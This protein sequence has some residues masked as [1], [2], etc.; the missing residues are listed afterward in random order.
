MHWQCSILAAAFVV[1]ACDDAPEPAIPGLLTDAC[2]LL[3]RS[4]AETITVTWPRV[5]EAFAAAF[6]RSEAFRTRA[7]W[8]GWHPIE[9]TIAACNLGTKYRAVTMAIG[10]AASRGDRTMQGLL[11]RERAAECGFG[12]A[13]AEASDGMGVAWP[14]SQQRAWASACLEFFAGAPG[15]PMGG[16]SSRSRT[17]GAD[18]LQG[19]SVTGSDGTAPADDGCGVQHK[20]FLIQRNDAMTKRSLSA[21]DWLAY[22]NAL[23]ACGPEAEPWFA[24]QVSDRDA[25][26]DAYVIPFLNGDYARASAFRTGA[27]N[28]HATIMTAWGLNEE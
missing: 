3:E 25:F 10:I 22:G 18:A 8:F 26:R 17:N 14:E 11:A 28:A 6:E 13:L 7:E 12:T 16:R 20:R 19:L 4:D 21:E 5:Q 15:L 27:P 2:A 9:A 24:A 23:A 1:T